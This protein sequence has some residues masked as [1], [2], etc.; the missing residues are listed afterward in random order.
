MMR[1]SDVA[2][3]NGRSH[4]QRGTPS[5]GQLVFGAIGV[6]VFMKAGQALSDEEFNSI[7]FPAGFRR[8]FIDAHVERRGTRCLACRRRVPRRRLTVD[9]IVALANGG[10]TSRANAQVRCRPCNSSKGAR[11]TP[12]D[13]VRGRR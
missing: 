12:V 13:Y 6:L 10:R 9:H 4:P 5:V 2:R 8:R 7:E 11:N 3:T 1:L